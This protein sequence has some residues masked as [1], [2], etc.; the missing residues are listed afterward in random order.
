M[1]L[2]KRERQDEFSSP[3]RR[4]SEEW[5]EIQ[6]RADGEIAFIDDKWLY[7]WAERG[8]PPEPFRY[9]KTLFRQCTPSD[10]SKGGWTVLKSAMRELC[11][12]FSIRASPNDSKAR[13]DWRP[14]YRLEWLALNHYNRCPVILGLYGDEYVVAA[15]HVSNTRSPFV[16]FNF[17][18]IF[19]Q[20]PE[21][22]NLKYQ[23]GYRHF[24][25][26]F[27]I[28]YSFHT[29]QKNLPCVITYWVDAGVHGYCSVWAVININGILVPAPYRFPLR[30]D[31]SD[32]T[33]KV[34]QINASCHRF[35]QKL[36]AS[37][38]RAIDADSVYKL[39][40]R[41]TRNMDVPHC[42]QED[43]RTNPKLDRCTNRLDVLLAIMKAMNLRPEDSQITGLIPL[44]Q[45][46]ANPKGE[47]KCH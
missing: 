2:I 36:G 12:V 1:Q 43:L 10:I 45:K 4:N 15:T 25:A 35:V 47:Q 17:Y 6:L 13:K 16:P 11:K 20:N 22:K 26:R 31:L 3:P 39:I 28:G 27:D 7:Q 21:W 32:L 19:H 9:H 42:V 46:F 33:G 37:Y 41:Y 44:S 40:R 30:N 18:Q 8:D 23:A 38:L 24:Q 5:H 29:E 34:E 14:T